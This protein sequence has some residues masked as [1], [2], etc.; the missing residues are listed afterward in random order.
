MAKNIPTDINRQDILDAIAV[1]SAG[2]V[3]HNFHESEKYDLTHDGNRYPPKAILG[4][5]ARRSAGH[6]LEPSDFSGGEGSPCFNVLRGCGFTIALKPEFETAEGS[7]WSDAE[8]DAAVSAYLSML[9]AEVAGNE[10]SKAEVNRRLRAT[11]LTH[12]TK[13]SVEYRMENIS[14]VLQGLNRQWIAGYKPAANVGAEVSRKIVASLERLEALKSEDSIP[15]SDP[16]TF[17]RKVRRNRLVPFTQQP[18][19]SKA[20]KKVTRAVVQYE[21]DPRVKAWVLQNAKGK[22]Q[23]CGSDAPFFDDFGLPFL[24]VH[25]IIPLA[26]GG[27][28]VVANAVALCPNCHRCC[29]HGSD[30]KDMGAKLMNTVEK[31]SW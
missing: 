5:A 6:V 25:H 9:R 10:F 16:E 14:S 28:D 1:Y 12:R 21:R 27:D 13:G 8:I 4:L 18:E 24:E 23:L 26:E 2:S 22:C 29:H 7:G 3:Q 30:R 15:E 11:V 17:E 20:P 31:R 19:G